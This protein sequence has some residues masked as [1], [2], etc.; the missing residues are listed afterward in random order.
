[1][2]D[3][4]GND[5]I[6]AY[7]RIGLAQFTTGFAVGVGPVW[8]SRDTDADDRTDRQMS[9]GVGDPDSGG[10]RIIMTAAV[11]IRLARSLLSSTAMMAADGRAPVSATTDP[12]QTAPDS[13]Q[14]GPGREKPADGG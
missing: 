3:T 5:S 11:A 7:G 4:N 10:I 6:P 8:V 9:V 1:M 13:S 2:T 14:A 12:R